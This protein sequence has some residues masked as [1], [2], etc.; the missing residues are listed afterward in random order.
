MEEAW[1]MIEEGQAL[2]ELKLSMAKEAH[3][4][5]MQELDS[6]SARNEELESELNV[7]YQE[8]VRL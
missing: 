8:M 1:T 4:V 2:V 7:A 6:L 5:V 3:Q